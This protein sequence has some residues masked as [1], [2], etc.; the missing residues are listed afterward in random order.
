M[1]GRRRIGGRSA[2]VR[3]L[4]QQVKRTE[5]LLSEPENVVGGAADR[6]PPDAEC[7]R[8]AIADL[9]RRHRPPGTPRRV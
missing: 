9:L 8:C 1:A 6:H 5:Q 7:L 4:A 3:V 2:R